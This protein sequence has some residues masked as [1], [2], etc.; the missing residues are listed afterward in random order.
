MEHSLILITGATAL[1]TQNISNITAGSYN[2]V[3]TDA[4]GCSNTLSAI[5]VSQPAVIGIGVAVTD[6]ACTGGNNGAIDV[7]VTGGT[8]N[9]SYNWS[10]N[11]NTQDL[12]N[13]TAGTYSVTVTDSKGCQQTAATVTLLIRQL[14]VNASVDQL[15]CQQDLGGID[16]TVNN[17]TGPLL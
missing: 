6:V 1:T 2:V 17:G 10:N 9:Y 5:T 16:L 4:N 7:T 15:V 8:P 3:V 12:T 11:T 13:V 14:S